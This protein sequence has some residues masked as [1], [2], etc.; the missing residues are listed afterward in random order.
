MKWDLTEPTYGDIVRTKVGSIYHYGIYV[1]DDEIIQF[2]LS[3]AVR[4][5]LSNKDVE[6]CL[7]DV[8]G[9][10]LDGFLEVGVPER[11]DKKRR[12]PKSTVATA[13]SRLGEKGYN[14]IYNNCEHFAHE[15]YFG[16]SFCSQTD[17]VREFFRSMPLVDVYWAIIPQ[18][19]NFERVY[20]R[21]RQREINSASHPDVK[22]EKY[23]VWKLLEH[24]LKT[25]FR[26]NIADVKF[27]KCDSGKW[28][29]DKCE[30]SLSHSHNL[31]CVAVSKAPIGVD[32]E[33]VEPLKVDISTK[34]LSDEQMQAYTGL[35]Q[36][37]RCEFLIDEWAKKESLFKLKNIPSVSIDQFKKLDG[38]VFQKQIDVFGQTYSL[39]VATNTPD[40][41]RIYERV[42]LS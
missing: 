29:C 24:A 31:V 14:I 22:R 18:E 10:L 39:A 2:G 33:K 40:K 21:S 6:V 23:Y 16:K 35:P 37:K 3:P 5:N 19:D 27:K 20:P 26:T 4:G 36:E 25:S 17:S 9:F 1:S 8:D 41:T 11:K 28:T 7:S 12:S 38:Q 15:C 30:F 34:I 42:D 13:R 32:V